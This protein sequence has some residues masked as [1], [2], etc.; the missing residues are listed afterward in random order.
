MI[1]LEKKESNKQKTAVA[2]SYNPDEAAPKIVASGRGFLADKIIKKA[3]ESQ[4]PL[5]QDD[6]LANTLSRLEI[7]EFIPPELYEVVAEVLIYV[8]RMDNMK[9]KIRNLGR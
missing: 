1:F 2:L 4:V 8:D 3:E 9:D 7:G 5:H 6:R